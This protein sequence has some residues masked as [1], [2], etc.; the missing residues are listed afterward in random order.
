MTND[1][2][3]FAVVMQKGEDGDWYPVSGDAFS[4]WHV[5]DGNTDADII[6]AAQEENSQYQFLPGSAGDYEV[7]I[8][9]LP[10]DITEYQF[11]GGSVDYDWNID[12]DVYKTP[13][14]RSMSAGEFAVVMDPADQDS[15]ELIGLASADVERAVRFS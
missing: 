1:G 11:A 3:L 12:L 6:A 5:A 7:T 2:T 14:G 15:A 4:G 8:E 9:N 13:T 10:G